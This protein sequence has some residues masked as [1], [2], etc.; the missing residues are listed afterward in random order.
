MSDPRPFLRNV[1]V[2]EARDTA[3]LR[4]TERQPFFFHQLLLRTDGD[5]R[6]LALETLR[7][8]VPEK[9]M[10]VLPPHTLAQAFGPG[11]L[12][13]KHDFIAALFNVFGFCALALAALGVY[14]IVSHSVSQRTREFGVRVAVGAS[15]RQIR[16][17]VLRDGT[18]LALIGIALGLLLTNETA[19]V[20]RRFLFSDYDRF[21]SR[22]YAVVAVG[23][24]AV[25]WLASWIPARRATRID[26]VEALRND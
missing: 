18:L 6:R 24:F 16:E 13:E 14:A 15:Q 26:P 19:G 20:L 22:V 12:R 23:L 5:G 3:T 25:A 9:G 10:I 7:T 11:Q 2:L 17:M 1:W 21:D 8:F 4:L